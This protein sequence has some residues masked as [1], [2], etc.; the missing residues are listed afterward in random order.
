MTKKEYECKRCHLTFEVVAGEIPKNGICLLC[1]Y[2][3][4]DQQNKMDKWLK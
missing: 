1:K 4:R 2:S 3:L